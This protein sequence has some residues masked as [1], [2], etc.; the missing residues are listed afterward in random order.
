M[1]T[2]T[3]TRTHWIAPFTTNA[4]DASGRQMAICG[5]FVWPEQHRTDPA[6]LGC[7]GCRMYLTN[8]DVI[9]PD[10]AAVDARVA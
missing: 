9:A 8:L 1:P 5:M 7:W 2:T 10:A 3:D 4:P 6:A